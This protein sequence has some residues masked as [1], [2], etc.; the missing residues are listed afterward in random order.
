MKGWRWW[1][2]AEGVKWVV[3]IAFLAIDR[4]EMLYDWQVSETVP[5]TMAL[6]VFVPTVTA[7][8]IFGVKTT[9]FAR[10]V[11]R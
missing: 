4:F 7:G 11:S 10:C 2:V 8:V 1:V 9:R 3:V 6:I 5:S